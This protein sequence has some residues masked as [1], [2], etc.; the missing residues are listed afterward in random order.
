MISGGRPKLRTAYAKGS[1][2]A[3]LILCALL[4]G[5]CVLKDSMSSRYQ[6]SGE[7]PDGFSLTKNVILVADNQ[8]NHL[9]GEPIWM[10][11]QFVTQFVR[12]SIR[13]VQQDLFGQEILRWVL[14]VYGTRMPV[15]HLGDAANMGCVGE[16]DSFLEIMSATGARPWVMAPGNHDA[17]L[18]GNMQ[19]SVDVWEDAC[20]R[21]D[22]PLT[23]DKL[24]EK[25][26]RHLHQQDSGFRTAYADIDSLP[27]SGEWR[28]DEPPG[29]IY[30]RAVAWSIDDT[31]P[32][33]SYVVQ[34]I[35]LGLPP[36]P[37]EADAQQRVSAILLDT[38]QFA[39]APVLLPVPGPNAGVNGDLQQDQLDVVTR[40]MTLADAGTIT[41]LMSHHPFGKLRNGSRAAV[42]A[43]R[44]QHNVPLYV[45]AH[46]HQG[47]Y[48]VR[49]GSEGWLELNVGSIV[50][51]PI[52][53]RTFSIQDGGDA[54]FL[55][56]TPLFRLPDQWG[57]LAGDRAPSCDAQWE[58]MPEDPDF[59]LTYLDGGMTDPAAT[60]LMLMTTLLH[61]YDRLIETVPSAADNQ[62]WP[63]L[64]EYVGDDCCSSDEEVG[65]GLH[66]I[67]EVAN[68]EQSV[69]A[70]IELGR[71]DRERKVD[72]LILHRDYRICQAL[73]A[74]K[75]NKIDR[76]A[77]NAQ[78]PYIIFSA[79][80]EDN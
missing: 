1:V 23:K 46:T 18:M 45:S 31:K 60:Q 74:S 61:T 24:V 71:F 59:Y 34:E 43:L 11:S 2:K 47:Q 48:F 10:R 66:K 25:Y 75:Y 42:D 6:I 50:D 55:F 72:D 57:T 78:D 39:S 56:R 38:S 77:P 49:G 68:R 63:D 32:H 5:G 36:P 12:V 33:R 70:L 76:R 35:D 69:E 3:L 16:F 80:S 4:A 67:I 62:R 17:Y 19:T 7:K 51:Y 8:L 37:G 30:L 20:Q 27:R 54:G 13:P 40:W 79:P 58:A 21:A 26:L 53:F 73:W 14:N 28:S 64:T 41:V 29:S 15:I 9:Y 22:G 44:R 52:E 65:A